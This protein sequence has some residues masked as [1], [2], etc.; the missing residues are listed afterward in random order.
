MANRTVSKIISQ[1]INIFNGVLDNDCSNRVTMRAVLRGIRD[2][3][4]KDE[5]EWYRQETDKVERES[6][7]KQ[8]PGVTFSGVFEERRLDRNLIYYTDVLVVDI[9]KK[10]MEVPFEQVMA[11][12]QKTPFIF[13]AFESPSNG[14]KALAVSDMGKDKHK[15]FFRGVEEY[16]MDQYGITIDTSGKNPGRLCFISYDPNI[17]FTDEYSPFDLESQGPKTFLAEKS[18]GFSEVVDIDFSKY[19]EAYDLE[20]VVKTV[21][22]WIDNG[23][24]GHYRKGNRN[25]YIFAMSCI[26]SE[27]GIQ[28]ETT[29]HLII[30]SFRSL[31]QEE[32]ET[33]VTSAYKRTSAEF[34]TRP[35]LKKKSNQSKLV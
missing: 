19:E 28:K 13:C 6:I 27:A 9:D 31:S 26:L 20:Y 21:R 18:R 4:W 35:I 33:T 8:F 22:G 30:S 24:V 3:Q 32:V 12:V 1:P 5:I 34:G 15:L 23:P 16:F 10:D 11:C 29:M 14:I 17:Y 7:K 2:G 25:N